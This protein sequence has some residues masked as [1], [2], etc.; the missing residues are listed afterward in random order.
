MMRCCNEMDP[1]DNEHHDDGNEEL[2]LEE[3]QAYES[4]KCPQSGDGNH[5]AESQ[6]WEHLE[7][8]QCQQPEKRKSEL[9]YSTQRT[10]LTKTCL[11]NQTSLPPAALH[12]GLDM[13]TFMT[14]VEAPT[15]CSETPESSCMTWL[16]S[17]FKAVFNS[18]F[19]PQ[20]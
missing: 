10:S 19:F 16:L 17:E 1:A 14:N 15:M 2:H 3:Q 13:S 9:T 18:C 12:T 7:G 20:D 8:V 5:H 6:K 4:V 11:P